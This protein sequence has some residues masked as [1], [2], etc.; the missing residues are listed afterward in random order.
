MRAG[1]FLHPREFSVTMNVYGPSLAP[2]AAPD[3]GVVG[4]G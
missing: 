4:G 2:I 1:G 3:G